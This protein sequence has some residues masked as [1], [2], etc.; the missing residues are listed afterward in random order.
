MA[1]KK[2]AGKKATSKKG[3]SK[4]QAQGSGPRELIDTGKNKMYGRRE[5]TGSK[6][7][8]FSEMDDQSRSLAADVRKP[9]KTKVKPGYGDKGDQPQKNTAGKKGAGKKGSKKR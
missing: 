1:T 2:G 4:K 9:A 6:K 7:G 8:Q 3:G 5:Q